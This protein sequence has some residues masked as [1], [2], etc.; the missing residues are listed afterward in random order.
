MEPL[1][2]GAAPH[3]FAQR[4]VRPQVTRVERHGQLGLE[5]VPNAVPEA[6]PG[7][8]AAA[9]DKTLVRGG[10]G[11]KISEEQV[12]DLTSEDSSGM[13]PPAMRGGLEVISQMPG[14]STDG[15]E[16]NGKGPGDQAHPEHGPGTAL[17]D[18]HRPRVLTANST[19]K[20]VHAGQT[21]NHAKPGPHHS[22][23]GACQTSHENNYLTQQL[24]ETLENVSDHG[25]GMLTLGPRGL[26]LQ[27]SDPGRVRGRDIRHTGKQGAIIPGPN[28]LVDVP[29]PYATPPPIDVASNHDEPVAPG[30]KG[31]LLSGCVKKR[32][33]GNSHLG[34]GALSPSLYV[35]VERGKMRGSQ[36][37]HP[38]HLPW[39]P[40]V[41]T[42]RGVPG[43]AESSHNITRS[44]GRK[45]ELRCHVQEGKILFK[46]LPGMVSGVSD[47]TI[48]DTSPGIPGSLVNG[49]G[50]SEELMINL[51]ETQWS[52]EGFT[53]HG[54]QGSIATPLFCTAHLLSHI[55]LLGRDMR[56]SL[57]NGLTVDPRGFKL[58]STDDT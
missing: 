42:S 41:R 43:R 29:Y 18:G 6:A 17:W 55:F 35:V 30:V 57:L 46:E 2:A 37:G 25:G 48:E 12:R 34:G 5:D 38:P 50:V 1:G 14:H 28:L 13:M 22:G 36:R 20:A 39:P 23:R 56:G 54:I 15:T 11:P 33:T 26:E 21:I 45:S 31:L 40:A 7:G 32:N 19:S 44:D 8:G 53:Q 27:P 3:L 24:I 47:V 51:K 9:H 52:R 4:R 16:Q 58:G 49:R 10:S